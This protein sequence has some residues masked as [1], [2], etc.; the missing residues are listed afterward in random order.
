MNRK[1]PVKYILQDFFSWTKT[2]EQNIHS[3]STLNLDV[4]FED[5][6]NHFMDRSSAFKIL[7]PVAKALTNNP[8][9]KLNIV[10]NAW[11]ATPPYGNGLAAL[12]VP[13]NINGASGYTVANLMVARADAV[14]AMLLGMGVPSNQ[15]IS[16]PGSVFNNKENGLKINVVVK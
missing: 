12:M 14:R 1:P 8:S 10:G 7:Q 9:L 13:T 4:K 11:K 16:L 3:G 15:L 6:S 5:S 2:P